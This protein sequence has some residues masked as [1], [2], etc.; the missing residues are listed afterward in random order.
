G[1]FT[2]RAFMA[3]KLDLAQAEA[4]A[5]VIAADSKSNHQIAL[6]QLRG[7][8]SSDIKKLRESLIHFASLI[9]LE[10]DFAEEDVTFASRQQLT[11]LVSNMHQ[12]I[13]ALAQSFEIGNVMKHGI[14]VVIA[15]MP[16][17]GKSTLLN[18]LLNE[19]RAI[20]SEIAGTTRDTIE[21]QINIEGLNFR[22]T[23]TAGIR[24]TVDAIEALGVERTYQKLKLSAVVIY[25]FDPKHVTP[26]E[27]LKT[28]DELKSNL[29]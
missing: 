13:D 16:N 20:V 2:W 9:E 26:V 27:V 25:M 22:F 12:T 17:V 11:Q 28:L 18:A 4:V 29:C 6:Q 21:E 14:P 23:D 3:G 24:Q 1:E 8:F 5:D 15:G 10:L 19:E 7:G